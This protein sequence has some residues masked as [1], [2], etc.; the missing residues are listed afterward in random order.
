MDRHFAITT[1]REGA[2]KGKLRAVTREDFLGQ[3]TIVAE[4]NSNDS[5][6]AKRL[7]HGNGVV[8]NYTYDL[9]GKV[10]SIKNGHAPGFEYHYD[11][12]G[13]IVG[14][15]NDNFGYDAQG[16][17]TW[18]SIQAHQQTRKYT[19][20]YDAVGNRTGKT[21]NGK[22]TGYSYS[23]AGQGNHLIAIESEGADEPGDLQSCRQPGADWR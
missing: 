19:Y 12:N 21:E 10:V 2:N 13:N 11:E 4:L 18:A 7:V 3:T 5:P 6:I 9:T 15:N 17:L 22:A 16:R 8:T 1:I 14:I 20:S 23:G